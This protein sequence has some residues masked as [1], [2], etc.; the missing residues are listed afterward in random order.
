[1]YKQYPKRA[2]VAPL[3]VL[4]LFAL[5]LWSC[6]ESGINGV[7]PEDAHLIGYSTSDTCMGNSISAPPEADDWDGPTVVEIT[8]DGLLITVFH[9]NAYLNCCLDEI[10]VEFSQQGR[11][12]VLEECEVAPNPCYCYCPFEVEAT[13]EVRTAGIYTL[14]IWTEGRLVWRGYIEVEGP[15]G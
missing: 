8:V 3:I 7:P 4:S 10:A 11:L 6:E 1:M 14:E 9:K 5:G 13:I 15:E 12:L 2:F